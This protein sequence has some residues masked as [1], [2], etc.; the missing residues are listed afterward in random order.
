MEREG[1][2][3]HVDESRNRQEGDIRIDKGRYEKS[4]RQKTE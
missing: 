4:K 1:L 3:S 2:K